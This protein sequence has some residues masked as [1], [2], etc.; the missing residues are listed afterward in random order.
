MRIRV[1]NLKLWY[2]S[3]LFML[4]NWPLL[5]LWQ[6]SESWSPPNDNCTKYDCQ[7]VKNEFITSKKQTTCPAFDPENCVPVSIIQSW[8]EYHF[9]FRGA[10]I[11]VN[12]SELMLHYFTVYFAT[13]CR[14]GLRFAISANDMCKMH[15]EHLP[16][17]Y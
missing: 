1:C 10:V 8:N 12:N 2:Q 6:P 16:F 15:K 11:F 7:K 3:E 9:L 4:T 5:H 14:N 17:W 13:N